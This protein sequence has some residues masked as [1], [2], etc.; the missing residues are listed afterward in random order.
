[1][2]PIGVL[3]FPAYL[4]DARGDLDLLN[5]APA[6][7]PLPDAPQ[8]APGRKRDTRQRSAL[9]E[10]VLANL[11]DARRDLDLAELVAPAE[12]AV[13]DAPQRARARKSDTT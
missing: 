5:P 12:P 7:R 2:N 9:T 4:L 1:M 10:A 11:L 8:R 6:E 3:T 13:P